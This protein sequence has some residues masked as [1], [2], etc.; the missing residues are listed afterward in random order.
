M[1]APQVAV[2]TVGARFPI[3]LIVQLACPNP[4]RFRNELWGRLIVCGEIK[5]RKIS[6]VGIEQE[7]RHKNKIKDRSVPSKIRCSI[8]EAFAVV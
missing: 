4:N 6:G 1:A 3:H 5:K 7:N 8:K 2:V